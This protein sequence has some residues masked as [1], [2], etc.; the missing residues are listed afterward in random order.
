[1]SRAMASWAAGDGAVLPYVPRSAMPT[2]S[3]LKPRACAPI[4]F[5]STPP[6]RPS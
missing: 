2:D 5:L 1:M 6:K 4:T 3:V